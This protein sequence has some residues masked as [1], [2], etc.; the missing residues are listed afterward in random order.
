[1]RL[2]E[3]EDTV[4][5]PFTMIW[6]LLLSLFASL[7]ARSVVNGQTPAGLAPKAFLS[8]PLGT[9]KPAGWLYDQLVVQTNGLAGHE[10]DFYHYVSE[11]DWIGGTSYYSSLEEAGSYWFNG[12]VPNG[13]LL[14]DP[15]IQSQVQQ[16]L[17]Y[18]LDHQ[19]STGWLGPEVNTTKPRYLWGRYPFFFG[20][21]QMVEANATLTDRVVTAFHKFV[22][23]ANTMLHNGEGLEDWTR[24]RWEDFVIVLQWL[25]DFHPEGNEDLLI[26]TMKQLK[27]TGDPWEDV[28]NETYF[29]K[30]AVEDLRNPF[31]VLTWHGVNMAEGLKALPST[32]RFT[33][34]QSDIDAASKGW[35]LLFQYHGRPSGIYA[36]DE[37]LA[38]LEAA[39]GGSYLYQVIGDPKFADRVERITYNA[40]PATLTGDMWSR[41]YLQQQ[42]QIAAKNM[43]PNPFPEDGPYSNVFGL[44]PNYPCCTVNHP[45]GWP[46]FISNS[47]VTTPDQASLVQ[48]YLGPYTVSTMLAATGNKVSVSVDTLYPFSDTLTT[49]IKA[50]KAFTY[51]VRIP[52]WVTNGTI[53]VNGGPSRPV[54]PTNGLH[55]VSVHA[56]TTEFTLDL[57]SEITIEER[58]HGSVAVHRGPLHYAFDISRSSRVLAQN[59]QQPL[60]V[61]L[62]F[63]ATEA[64]QYAIDPSTLTFHTGTPAGGQLPSPIFDSGLPPFTISVAACPIDW[65]EGGNTFAA[66]PPTDPACTGA[67]T[68]ITLS[69]FGS[70]K[71][72][73]GEFPTFKAT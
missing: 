59:A 2:P 42:N 5:G 50:T 25:Y 16:F 29:P 55:A 17:D 60:A 38:G 27:Y 47:F 72:R 51:Y 24:T 36:A 70:T 11:S 62:E 7:T 66:A 41:Q 10:H 46:K 30:T 53:S 20:A 1:M 8:L 26:D 39:R 22:A 61:D 4:N 12:M 3:V 67:V 37:Y 73:I 6:S 71:L 43:T 44:E 54:S 19:D 49:T 65:A 56:G 69:P 32:Y 57:P 45:Q 18:V 33:H 28:F 23:L 68:N 34:N 31:P 48:V 52:S 64:W 58:P 35:D 21:I 40:L 63:D 15:T 14:D 13:I 9:V